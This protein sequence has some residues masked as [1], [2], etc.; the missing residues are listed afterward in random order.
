MLG[1]YESRKDIIKSR[2]DDFK[3]VKSEDV[4]Y[5]LCF[6]LLTPQSSARN[7][8][9]VVQ[10]L[11]EMDFRNNNFNPVKLVEGGARFHRNKSKYLI[12]MKGKY[13]E[14]K[15][16]VDKSDGVEL[17]EYLVKNVKGLGYK[18]ASHFLRNIGRRGLAI[19]D[20]HILKNLVKNKVIDEIPKSLSK[21]KYF[22]IEGKFKEFSEKIGIDMD[23]VD[24]LFWS[25]QTG[26]VFK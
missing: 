4:F 17:R 13:N 20:R 18:E 21:K 6:C 10:K 7:C 24:L 3:Q 26:E 15:S 19:L 25:M 9:K 5:E 8:D 22:E 2:L 14:I 23:E 1:E 12:E 11:K 16:E